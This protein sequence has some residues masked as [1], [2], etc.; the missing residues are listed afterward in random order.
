MADVQSTVVIKV[1]IDTDQLDAELAGLSK[2]FDRFGDRDNKISGGA[3]SLDNKFKRLD[4]AM[5]GVRRGLTQMTA[6]FGKLLLMM[7]K[8]NF[9]AMAAELGVFTAGLLAIKLALITGR[10][11]VSLYN[12][13]LKGL[14]VAAASVATG[15]SVAAA[16]MREFQEAQMVP[17]LGGGF[18]GGMKARRISRGMGARNMGLLGG[19]GAMQ[20]A[21]AQA[22]GGF[23]GQNSAALVAAL[24]NAAG[25][26]DPA[27]ITSVLKNTTVAGAVGAAQNLAG[28]RKGALQ[29]ISSFSGLTAALT[30]GGALKA[31]FGGTGETLA[32]TFLGTV[33]TGFADMKGLFADVGMPMLEPM[34]QAFLQIANIMRENFLVLQQIIQRFGADSMAPTMV[35]IFDRMMR[36]ITENIIDHL[37]KIQQ[38]GDNFVGFFKAMANFFR[39]MGNWL[40]QFEPAANVIIDMFKAGSKANTSSLFRDLSDLVVK[41][42]EGL[43]A[44]GTAV[45]NLFGGIFDLFSGGNRGFFEDGLP[46]LIDVMNALTD[47]LFPAFQNLWEKIGPTFDMLPAVIA[48]LATA[49]NALAPFIGMFAKAINSLMGMFPTLVGLIALSKMGPG[50]GLI[51]G[52]MKFG[53]GFAKMTLSGK[54]GLL[55]RFFASKA[56]GMM[57]SFGSKQV[58]ARFAAHLPTFM[59]QGGTAGAAMATTGGATYAQL[60]GGLFG[61]VGG[62]AM[63]G[64]GLYQGAQGMRDAYKTGRFTGQGALGLGMAMGGYAMMGGPVTAAVAVPLLAIALATEGILAYFGNKKFKRDSKNAMKEALDERRKER[65]GQVAAGEFGQDEFDA[66]TK[67]KQL[68][69]RAMDAAVN[70]KGEF[71]MEGDTREFREY[72]RF[73]GKDPN[74]IHRDAA[75]EEAI[76]SNEL[77]RLIAEI[78]SAERRFAGN[79]VQVT[80]DTN[81]ALG[82]LGASLRLTSEDVK[83]LAQDLYGIDLHKGVSSMAG[84]MIAASQTIF[85]RN[86][87]FAPDFSKSRMGINEGM[88]SA[89]KAL[90]AL[91]DNFNV[92]NL[93]A[94]STAFSS[95]EVSRGMNAD[96][97]GLSSIL[98]IEQQA[99]RGVFGTNKAAALEAAGV[100]KAQIFAEMGASYNIPSTKLREIYESGGIGG[101]DQFIGDQQL[102]R[103]GIAGL[104]GDMSHKDR[105]SVFSKM[106][107]DLESQAGFKGSIGGGIT[108]EQ[109]DSL[110]GIGLGTEFGGEGKA[111]FDSLDKGL[112]Y[113]QVAAR[114]EGGDSA[115]EE[116]MRESMNN[117]MTETGDLDANRNRLLET[118]NDAVNKPLISIN[119][120]ETGQ[121]S[122]T[123]E[124]GPNTGVNPAG[125]PTI[126]VDL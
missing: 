117:W 98:E 83:K 59:A 111:Y 30:G 1:K 40:G 121:G 65:A 17:F 2:K 72:L 46:M 113:E 88:V 53:G 99:E 60:A 4:N 97:A 58:G 25:G 101:L 112:I 77:T 43:M 115:A 116:I 52:A 109:Y 16:A 8:I 125:P 49:I 39:G 106:G 11:A 80:N 63:A 74:T 81:E 75:F 5:S 20:V 62:T 79:L 42:R 66:L 10:A 50:A 6:G 123:I 38:M 14:S 126:P 34:R 55:P 94:F 76:G 37:G 7:G 120:M 51:G 41:N 100:A 57:G 54:Q 36:F 9:L 12:I 56:S 19:Q 102:M 28:I 122:Y 48:G 92:D 73:I 95:Y 64:V 114:A 82:T 21:S 86:R 44:F 108:A 68:L 110:F 13:A 24:I 3:R 15:L 93:T 105:L 31:G 67:E 22:R 18:T 35:T 119:G 61:A 26:A 103:R 33:K 87:G 29:G 90:L 118:I 78:G 104:K 27:A 45:G 70:D 85:S 91:R 69:E 71:K 89:D 32:N 124:I 84:M 96:I 47:K 107:V 23:S